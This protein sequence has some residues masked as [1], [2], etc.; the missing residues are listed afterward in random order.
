ML[1]TPLP[2]HLDEALTADIVAGEPL[3]GKLLLDFVLRGDT[4]MVGSQYP[5]G[6]PA[7]H[8]RPADHHILDGV[9]QCVTHVE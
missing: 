3:R 8:A 1:L 2:A 9:V 5:P 7:C 6:G 4:G